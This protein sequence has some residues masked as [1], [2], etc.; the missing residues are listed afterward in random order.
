V[1]T[2]GL[3][4]DQS[5][6]C[7]ALPSRQKI[8]TSKEMNMKWFLYVPLVL[9]LG[10][11]M[12]ALLP[13]SNLRTVYDAKRLSQRVA[14]TGPV[15]TEADIAHLPPVV[16]RFMRR[17]GVIGKPEITSVHVTFDT[18]LHSAPGDA[19]MQGE[20]HQ[21]DVI[22]PVRRLFF[23]ETRMNGLPVAVLHDYDGDAA[24]MRVRLMRLYDVVKLSGPEL[25]KAETVTILNDLAAFAPSALI[26]PKA[27]WEE[28]DAAHA[29]VTYSNGP[30]TVSAEL[31]FNA[32][33]DLIDFL[34]KDR[35]ELQKDGS[36]RL[37]PWTTPLSDHREFE[38]RRVPGKG[39]A[40]YLR[41]DGPFT[42]GEFIVKDI[43]FNT[44]E[45][46]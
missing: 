31:T 8:V 36:L 16:Q 4:L 20:S 2:S 29:K 14:P 18:T 37:Q 7:L 6:I 30:Y 11:A 15:L 21:I 34:S 22:E 44:P 25:S 27:K 28:I 43:H 3:D 41:D 13:S 42:Y 12:F 1:P 32:D 9:L 10:V 23:M 33:G 39:L 46:L 24:S 17:A 45:T 26:G 5:S 38:G 35:S 40:I 19:G